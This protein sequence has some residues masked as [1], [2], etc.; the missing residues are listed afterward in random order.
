MVKICRDTDKS[1]CFQQY[2][3][4][5]HYQIWYTKTTKGWTDCVVLVVL[6]F[7]TAESVRTSNIN[8]VGSIK[9]WNHAVSRFRYCFISE[10]LFIEIRHFTLLF[11]ISSI[12]VFFLFLSI[13]LNSGSAFRCCSDECFRPCLYYISLCLD[14]LPAQKYQQVP[15]D[16]SL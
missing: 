3:F 15:E 10:F 2:M 6:W 16:T 4:I 8:S 14:L 1:I 11:S 12:P 13:H 5:V 7:K 9:P